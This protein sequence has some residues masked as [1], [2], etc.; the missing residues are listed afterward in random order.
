MLN[1][2]S[3]LFCL[4]IAFAAQKIGR[5]PIILVGISAMLAVWSVF[6]GLSAGYAQTGSQAMAGGVLAM[7]YLFNAAYGAAW[8]SLCVSRLSP[9]A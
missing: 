3:L 8:S 6:T 5:R 4:G 2:W 7:I 1:V 9:A